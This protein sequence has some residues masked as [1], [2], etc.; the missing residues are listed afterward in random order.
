MAV[1]ILAFF[2]TNLYTIGTYVTLLDLLQAACVQPGIFFGWYAQN[3]CIQVNGTRLVHVNW[4]VHLSLIH[5]TLVYKHDVADHLR[6]ERILVYRTSGP[7]GEHRK[8]VYK[9]TSQLIFVVHRD[10]CIQPRRR[11]SPMRNILVSRASGPL[12]DHRKSYTN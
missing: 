11:C 12:D 5:R 9:L 2:H 3:S 1:M 4:T 10:T 8:A 6:K 7:L